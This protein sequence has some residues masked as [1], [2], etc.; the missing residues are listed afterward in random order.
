MTLQVAS[1]FDIKQP[2]PQ[3]CDTFTQPPPVHFQLG[4]P[5]TASPDTASKSREMSPLPGKP[6]SE[7]FELGEFNLEFSG[8]T[9][10]VLRKNVED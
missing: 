2:P 1:P 9:F 4:F 6:G 7:I 3:R 10:G 5:R 8:E